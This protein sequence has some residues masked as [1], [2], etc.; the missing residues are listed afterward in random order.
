MYP[1]FNV[2]IG[3]IVFALFFFVPLWKI[4]GK[5]GHSPWLALLPFVPI[6]G[7]IVCLI[8]LA[9]GRWPAVDDGRR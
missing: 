3:P 5:T 6:V 7:G 8:I 9:I 4:F 1:I 2:V